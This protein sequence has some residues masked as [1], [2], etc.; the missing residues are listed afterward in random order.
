VGNPDSGDIGRIYRER[1]LMALY[2]YSM[3]HSCGLMFFKS[4]YFGT[5]IKHKDK[6]GFYFITVYRGMD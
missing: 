5:N 6:I 2:V 1:S 4:Y 3:L